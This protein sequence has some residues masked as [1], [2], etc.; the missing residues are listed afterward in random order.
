DTLM[1]VHVAGAP[2]SVSAQANLTPARGYADPEIGAT[3]IYATRNPGAGKDL[4]G[5][6]AAVQLRLRVASFRTGNWVASIAAMQRSLKPQST[7]RHRGDP[8]ISAAE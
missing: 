1:P 7:G 2:N 6:A 3:T 8:P 4:T 5:L